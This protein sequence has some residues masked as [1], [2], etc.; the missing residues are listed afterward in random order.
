MVIGGGDLLNESVPPPLFVTDS[1]DE[2]EDLAIDSFT[3][4]R[5]SV[6]MPDIVLIPECIL[7][8]MK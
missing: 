2:Q 5:N 7:N 8:D 6:L 1:I 3:T 4:T